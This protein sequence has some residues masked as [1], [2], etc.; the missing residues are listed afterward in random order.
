MR[1]GEDEGEDRAVAGRVCA[2]GAVGSQMW[3]LFCVLG[4]SWAGQVGANS[5][6][7][8]WGCGA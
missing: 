5:T 7:P 1:E 6:A 8:C 3:A 4:V 2:R